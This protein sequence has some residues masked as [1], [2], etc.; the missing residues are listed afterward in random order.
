[1]AHIKGGLG[2]NQGF[3]SPSRDNQYIVATGGTITQ[4][5]DY[6]VHTFTSNGTF[7]ITQ[8][9]NYFNNFDYLVQGGGG[10][11]GK[12]TGNYGGGG[13]GGGIAVGS[14]YGAVQTYSVVVGAGGSNPGGTDYDG[15]DGGSSSLA[16]I[17]GCGGG[18]GFGL[19]SV[20]GGSNCDYSASGQAG[21]SN[22]S[23][24]TSDSLGVDGLFSSISG[25]STQ[26]GR[27]GDSEGTARTGVVGQGG[28]A[29]SG[30]GIDSGAGEDGIVI[31]RYYSPASGDADAN[32]YISAITTAGGTLSGAEEAAI[33]TFFTDIKASGIFSKAYA[34]Y[35]FL[36][37]V[38]NSNKIN[39]VNPGT[40]DLT[41]TGT[42]NHSVTGSYCASS[43]S[44]YADTGFN[45]SSSVADAESNLSFGGFG[46]SSHTSGYWGLN[47][48]LGAAGF[49]LL[50]DFN[51]NT[52]AYFGDLLT[53]GGTGGWNGGAAMFVNRTG[54]TS[55][56]ADII[57]SG[58][59]ATWPSISTSTS[60]FTKTNTTIHINGINGSA[61]YNSGGEVTYAWITE[62]LTTSQRNDILT[63]GNDLMTAF[64]RNMFS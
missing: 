63:Y 11:G 31:V 29:G 53:P 34:I 39:A 58:S 9:G 32:A 60:T 17:V 27:G 64:N 33:Q 18:K 49:L 54:A 20:N 43:N 3:A 16:S 41:F 15:I 36:G 61:G 37:G 5:G 4:D 50:G 24:N 28:H 42:W 55:W 21:A 12:D 56:E 30:L 52:E 35:P 10:S 25:V 22:A 46:N 26:Y 51:N 6:K 1:M 13:A 14:L 47:G 7:E 57:D 8:G 45:I 62:G 59:S 19:A 40:Y 23:N 48:G 38:A 2:F 44:N